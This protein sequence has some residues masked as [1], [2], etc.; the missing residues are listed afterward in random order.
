V[1]KRRG[2]RAAAVECDESG[3]VIPGNK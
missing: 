3:G 1:G 2:I